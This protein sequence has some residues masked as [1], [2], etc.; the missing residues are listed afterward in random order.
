[1]D[2]INKI[3]LII[4]IFCIPRQSD[5]GKIYS[6]IWESFDGKSKLT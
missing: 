4:R 5:P 6:R 3:T 2:G 1:M